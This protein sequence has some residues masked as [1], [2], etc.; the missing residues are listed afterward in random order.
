MTDLAS[1]GIVVDSTSAATAGSNLDTMTAAA[2]RAEAAAA[3][4]AGEARMAMAGLTGISSAVADFDR[5]ATALK[6]SVDPV[7]AAMDRVNAEIRETDALFKVGAIGADEYGRYLGTLETRLESAVSA[8]GALNAMQARG[9][10]AAKFTAAETLNLSRQFADIGVT[11]AMGMNPL[12]ILIQQG[13]QIADIFG[14]AA[15]RG[16]TASS[17]FRQVGQQLGILTVSTSASAAANLAQAQTAKAAADAQLRLAIAN[18]SAAGGAEAAAVAATQAAA[19]N[20]TLTA[21]ANTATAAQTVALAPLAVVAGVVLAVV[22]AATAGLAIFTQ[23]INENGESAEETRKRLGLTAEQMEKVKNTGVGMGDTLK[24]VFQVAGAAIAEALDLKD[25]WAAIQKG[26]QSAI[27][28]TVGFAR[29]AVGT[30]GA[31]VGGIKAVWGLLPAAMGDLMVRAANGVIEI[32][33]RMVNAVIGKINLIT[34]FV[35]AAAGLAGLPKLFGTIENFDLAPIENRWEGAGKSALSAFVTGA[36]DGRDAALAGLDGVVGRIIAQARANADARIKKEA[37]KAPKAKAGGADTMTDAERDY[38]R[39]VDQATKAAEAIEAEADARRALNDQVATGAITY[40]ELN[41]ALALE[42]TLQPFRAEAMKVEGEQRKVLLDLIQRITEATREANDEALRGDML[43]A[44]EDRAPVIEMLRAELDLIGKTAR[45]RAV[46]L[47]VLREEQAWKAK[48]FKA[49]D[50]SPETMAAYQAAIAGAAQIANLQ[51]D[52]RQAQDAYND[53]LTETLDLL[54]DIDG[55]ARDAAAGMASAFGRVGKAMGDALTT[56]TGYAKKQEELA[57]RRRADGVT[58][59]EVAKIDREASRA[60]VGYYGDMIGAAR[61][62]FKE[63]SDGWKALQAVEQGY[64]A[65]EFAMSVKAMVQKMTETTTKVA[66]DGVAVASHVT[67]ATATVAADATTTASGIA[68][69]ASRIFAALGPYGFPVVAAMLAVMAG[70]GAGG[71]GGGAAGVPISE[72]RQREQGAGSVLGDASAKSESIA[73]SLEIVAS[74][75]NRDLEFSNDM[76]RALRSIDSQIGV[77]AAALARSFGAGGMLDTSG[78]G[79]GETTS[80]PGGLMRLFSPISGLFGTTKTR[81]LLDQGVQFDPGSLEAILSGGLSGSAYQQV[82]TNTKKKFFGFAYSD[83]TSTSTSTTGLDGD[84]LRQTELLIGSL[85]DGVLAAAGT[86]GVEGAAATLAAFQ[87]NLGK[88]SLKD[89]TGTEIQAALEGIF[90]KLADDMAGAVLPG[91][92][93]VQKVGEGLFETLTR[94]ARQYQVIDVTLSAVEKTFGAVGV[95]SIG[96]RER[97]IDL[98]GSLDDFTEQVGFYSETFLTEAERLAPVQSAVNAELARL[99]LAG[100]KTRDQFKSV[101]QGIDVSTEAGAKLFAAMM[102]LAP[103]FAKVTEEAEAIT[104]AKSA[105]SEAYGRESEVLADTIDR[106]GALS[107]K[108]RD[109]GRSLTTGPAAALS[110]EAAY[111]AARADFDRVAAMAATGNETAL[112]DLQSVSEAYLEASK[113]YFA[114]SRGYFDDLAAV[115]AAVAAAEEIAGDQVDVYQ[116]QLDAM[117]DQVGQLIDLNQNVLSVEQ[118]IV[119]LT[120]L[121]G[122]S[123]AAGI[124]RTPVAEVQAATPAPTTQTAAQPASQA[125]QPANDNSGEILS[126]LQRIESQLIAANSQRGAVAMKTI[127]EL[128]AQQEVLRRQAR[129]TMAV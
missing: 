14:T 15:A 80:A 45:E 6:A 21:A 85:R 10:T 113:A 114:S 55:Q 65:W 125:A 78:L 93:D 48:G 82:S 32:V 67:A 109:Y 47:A 79:L 106:F 95:S 52:M 66:A 40:A 27:D 127:E 34:G 104:D 8:Q 117:T 71:G 63:G 7:A 54:T 59:Q 101:V 121:L 56:M 122:G 35:N 129:E 73:R 110:P 3:S 37:G 61:G 11:A 69:G 126:A 16:A 53:S 42:K 119:N 1:L 22:A 124:A 46:A 108:L 83:K 89:M 12:M 107:T 60:R 72:R 13:P 62:F 92:S 91:L 20:A 57:V 102:A 112:E 96:A 30:I 5:R 39:A 2:G 120:A 103:A 118:A 76:L 74:N 19:A 29:G 84:F 90:G 36:V 33:E 31:A 68:A 115:R 116:A 44:A 81:T 98:F 43:K 41:E 17:I 100:V 18:V 128:Q 86:L 24:A 77:V 105:L 28:W 38:D 58:A 51:T 9:A 97:L 49:E 88:L 111:A 4:L 99:G 75:T 64:R 23:Q 25:V 87:V 70:L 94:V 26:Y 123:G 50:A